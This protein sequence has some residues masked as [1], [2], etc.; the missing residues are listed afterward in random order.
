MKNQTLPSKVILKHDMD[1]SFWYIGRD[2][3]DY[4]SEISLEAG[5]MLP[6]TGIYGDD[7]EVDVLDHQLSFL[8]R[9]E[10]SKHDVYLVYTVDIEHIDTKFKIGDSV[11]WSNPRSSYQVKSCEVTGIVLLDAGEAGYV[12]K[13]PNRGEIHPVPEQELQHE[14][15][16]TPKT[17]TVFRDIL[18][19]L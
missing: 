6:V 13:V 15:E 8:G 12:V 7:Y 9:G 19:D 2:G 16:L 17:D 10:I 4:E 5:H 14:I 1:I 11:I 3:D 18:R